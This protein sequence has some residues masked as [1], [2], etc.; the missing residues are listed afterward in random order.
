MIV[1]FICYYE[2]R[3]DYCG[4]TIN[5][6]PNHKPD[7]EELR[8]DGILHTRTKQFCSEECYELY[9]IENIKEL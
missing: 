2:V 9:F 4:S 1:N 5:H 8:K 6:Y 7:N 3:C